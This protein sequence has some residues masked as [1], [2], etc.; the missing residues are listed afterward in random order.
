MKNNEKKG[1]YQVKRVRADLRNGDKNSEGEVIIN[2]ALIELQ[3]ESTIE[4][5]DVI[6]MPIDKSN[7]VFL[8]K[9]YDYGLSS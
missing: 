1:L 9:Y 7:Y 4:I 3:N 5:I 2:T 8:I 6:E